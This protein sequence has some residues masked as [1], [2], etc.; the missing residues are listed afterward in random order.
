MDYGGWSVS[1]RSISLGGPPDRFWGGPSFDPSKTEWSNGDRCPNDAGD[2][3]EGKPGRVVFEVNCKS[4]SGNPADFKLADQEVVAIGFLPRGEEMGAPPNA[5]SAPA[6][7]A[8]TGV[9]PEAIDQKGCR[10]TA[11]GNPGVTPTTPTTA[12]VATPTT[13]Q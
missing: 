6:N 4:V 10:P 9:T 12:P 3:G 11:E 5:A 8:G 2:A 7:D 13:G 1:K